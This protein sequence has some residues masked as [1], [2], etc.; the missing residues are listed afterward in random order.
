MA[1][2]AGA[3]QTAA[4]KPPQARG[5][6]EPGARATRRGGEDLAPTTPLR[7][8]AA[9]ADLADVGSAPAPSCEPVPFAHDLPIAEASGAV[10][11]VIDGVPTVMV[12]ADS[13]HSGD[14]LLVDPQT[15]AVRERGKLPLGQGAGDDLEGLAVR[16]DRFWALTSAGWLRAW[17]R[18]SPSVAGHGF[19]LVEGPTAIGP[20]DA[21]PA[22]AMV[23]APTM[24]NCGRNFEGLC[25]MPQIEKA[26]PSDGAC[27]GMAA[28]KA[29][30]RLYCVIET[31]GHLAIDPQ[32]SISVTQPG[33]LADCNID[34]ETLWVGS[35]FFDF[36]RVR[37]IDNWRVPARARVIE[38]GAIGVGF[39]EAIAVAG[40]AMYRFSDTQG[41]PS[42]VAK[43]R[44]LPAN[45]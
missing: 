8:V 22:T 25:L 40:D 7:A 34:R 3:C 1:L 5:D 45:K 28:S 24:V 19:D 12:I 21:P 13:G 9:V 2:I 29:D 33:A 39:C 10:A 37:R 32:R 6:W 17:V 18:R 23:C 44:C 43:F 38:L 11:S 4:E 31:A 41:T 14:Y 27:I 36:N 42:A 30:G 35:N 15:G 26:G 20:V 16:G